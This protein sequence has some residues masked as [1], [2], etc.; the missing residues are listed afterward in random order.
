MKKNLIGIGGP[1]LLVLGVIIL[2]FVGLKMKERM[3]LRQNYKNCGYFKVTYK[4]GSYNP[5]FYMCKP[6]SQIK[7]EKKCEALGFVSV[8]DLKPGWSRK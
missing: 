2:T 6:I 5:H 7:Q 3:E 4:D 1:F 8:F